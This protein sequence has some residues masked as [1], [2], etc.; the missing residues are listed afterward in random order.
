VVTDD[1]LGQPNQPVTRPRRFWPRFTLRVLLAVVTL[2]CIG[3]A[4]WT[5]RAR[6]QARIVQHIEQHY[7]NVMYDWEPQP[8]PKMNDARS[9]VPAWLLNRLGEDFFHRVVW[10]HVRGDIDLEQA[11]RLS[12]IR[13]LTI[14]KEDLTDEKLQPIAKLRDLRTLTIQSDKH[15]SLGDYP[16]TTRIGDPSLALI[17][18]LPR[19]EKLYVDGT[20]FTAEGLAALAESQSLRTVWINHCHTSVTPADIQPLLQ[21]GRLQRVMVRK[22][23]SGIGEEEVMDW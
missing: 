1:K 5:H 22:W 8:T 13:D 7:G 19:L 15:Q 14:W 16:D 17:A 21:T 20:D 3:L 9:P 4:I 23:T 10:A 18:R 2:L 11:S 12:A 6:E